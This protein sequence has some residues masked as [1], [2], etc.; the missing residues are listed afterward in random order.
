MKNTLKPAF[1]AL[2]LALMVSALCHGQAQ[3]SG[4]QWG[5][6]GYRIT[7]PRHRYRARISSRSFT[8]A[9]MADCGLNGET[10]TEAG[11]VSTIWGDN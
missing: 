9:R 10:R 1:M 3:W 4:E 7:I 2:G 11:Q 6:D 5:D 8:R